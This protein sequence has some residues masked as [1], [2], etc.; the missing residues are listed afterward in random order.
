M[1]C[2]ALYCSEARVLPPKQPVSLF[3]EQGQ[4]VWSV[5]GP[6]GSL[7]RKSNLTPL[8][9][10]ASRLVPDLFFSVVVEG[11]G[12]LPPRHLCSPP[13][14]FASMHCSA[15]LLHHASDCVVPSTLPLSSGPGTLSLCSGPCTL[16]LSSGPDCGGSAGRA[17]ARSTQHRGMRP[18]ASPHAVRIPHASRTHPVCIPYESRTHPVRIPYASRTNPVRIQYACRTHPVRIPC[19]FCAYTRPHAARQP[20]AAARCCLPATLL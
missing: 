13:P 5:G 6:R 8:N 20:A 17:A 9:S 3:S 4:S 2:P 1:H 7:T 16:P 14:T 11:A 10:G 12:A 18:P 19:T 15:L